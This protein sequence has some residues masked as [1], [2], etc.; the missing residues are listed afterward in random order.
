MRACERLCGTCEGCEHER[1]DTCAQA[2][3]IEPGEPTRDSE[4]A[5]I[6]RTPA[7]REAFAQ[8]NRYALT[9][10]NRRRC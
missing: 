3:R 4:S 9:A 7:P 1:C 5:W 8:V 6:Q 10:S 2:P